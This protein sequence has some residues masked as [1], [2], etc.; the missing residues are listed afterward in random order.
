MPLMR[1]RARPPVFSVRSS[2]WA[3]MPTSAVTGSLFTAAGDHAA[4]AASTQQIAVNL[5]MSVV[6]KPRRPRPETEL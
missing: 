4:D 1:I 3:Q 5:Y 2:L 6:P